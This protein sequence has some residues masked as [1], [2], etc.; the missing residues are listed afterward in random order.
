MKPYSSTPP[1]PHSPT[2]LRRRA[3]LSDIGM[4][5]TGLVL[6]KMLSDDG[7]ARAGDTKE[8]A[9]PVGTPEFTPK[10]KSVI[11]I[12]LVGGMSQMETF[13]PKPELN[14]WAGKTFDESPYKSY[15]DSPHLKKNR[16][17][18]RR[19]GKEC[20][21]RSRANQLKHD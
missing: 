18:E 11:W 5:F 1:L 8:W 15:L 16:S 9:P 14:K 20:R 21:S 2:R 19:V 12:F 6:G 17:E 13:D 10:A 7:I 4:G 3:F